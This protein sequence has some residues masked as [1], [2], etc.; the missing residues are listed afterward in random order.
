MFNHSVAGEQS[1]KGTR[2][3]GGE[4][5]AGV[6]M[7]VYVGVCTWVCVRRCVYVG[8]YTWLRLC[9]NSHPAPPPTQGNSGDN[10]S[11]TPY[12]WAS[13]VCLVLLPKGSSLFRSTMRSDS[14]DPPPPIRLFYVLFFFFFFFWAVLEG[15]GNITSLPQLYTGA[16]R[17]PCKFP[18]PLMSNERS[19]CSY[20]YTR[21]YITFL[22]EFHLI[23]STRFNA[24]RTVAALKIK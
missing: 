10:N 3:R 15:P 4:W 19:E 17:S 16:N 8:V 7:C 21:I 14:R 6:Y 5:S 12:L 1:W 22:Y 20:L 24:K 18:F 23:F 9:P 2:R 11:G 13:H